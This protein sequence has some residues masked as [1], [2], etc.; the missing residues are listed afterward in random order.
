MQLANVTQESLLRSL[1]A[2]PA[3]GISF[4]GKSCGTDLFLCTFWAP[5]RHTTSFPSQS[6]RAPLQP[7]KCRSC[8]AGAPSRMPCSVHA[9]TQ[10]CGRCRLPATAYSCPASEVCRRSC[11]PVAGV[12]HCPSPSSL[13]GC[14]VHSI[15]SR[16][17]FRCASSPK[18][19]LVRRSGAAG[20]VAY[21]VNKLHYLPEPCPGVPLNCPS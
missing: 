12:P 4:G 1:P 13:P 15:R 2:C 19:T 21:S 3:A 16:A 10:R 7:P 18:R 6:S 5:D 20:C 17:K 14:R 8:R 11:P 9:H